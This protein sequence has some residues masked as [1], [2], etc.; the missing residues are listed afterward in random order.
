MAGV[1]A[2]DQFAARL[3][4]RSR[5]RRLSAA[6]IDRARTEERSLLR[7]WVMRKTIHMIPTDDAGWMLP[8]FEPLMERWS[9]RRLE[10]LGMSARDVE[11][12]LRV[13]AG[14]LDD[15]PITRSA[16]AELVGEAGIELNAQTRLHVVGL[17]VVSGLALLGPDCGA[18]SCLVR[19]EDWIGA[20]PRFDRDRAL[21][22]FA[23]RYLRAFGP[24]TDRDFAYWAGLGLREVRVG[25]EMISAE[26]EQVRVGEE[27]LL[28]L[29]GALPR[30]PRTGQVRMLGNFDTYL[31]GYEDRGFAV[32]R[33]HATHVKEG[34]GGW[35]RPV[36]AR[37]GVVIGGWRSART[38]G[39]LEVSLNLPGEERVAGREAIKAEVEDIA[40]FTGME[41]AIVP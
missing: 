25:L 33:E 11:R 19:R 24:A 13:I 8:L 31:L 22:E 2:Q 30:L 6:E 23:R 35:I 3:S 18:Q 40:R 7:T 4:F 15:G 5:S 41:V 36:V 38:G 9:R 27:T 20:A 34:G 32:D 16:A 17:A 1:Q 28:S 26:I 37:D 10:Q 14:A 29:R 39:R 21:G 12:A